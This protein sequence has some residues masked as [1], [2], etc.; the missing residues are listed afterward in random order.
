MVRLRWNEP[1]NVVSRSYTCSYCGNP[2]A[3]EKGWIA[4][5]P[6]SNV[7]VAYIYVCHRC[8]RPTFFDVDD[9]QWPG[10]TFGNSVGDVP[11]SVRELYDE[12]RRAMGVSSYTAAVLCCRKLLMHIAVSKGAQPG[13]Q[14]ITYVEYL[15][16]NHFIPPDAKAWVDHVRTKGNEANHEIVIMSQEDAQ[17]LVSFMEMLLKVIFEFPASINR[18]AA[19]QQAATQGAVTNP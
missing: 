4:Y 8:T 7:P 15:A 17:E 13:Q 3:S 12:A 1:A 2:L 9:S 6:N 11:D 18:K 16:N 10:A 19:R 5:S 14:F